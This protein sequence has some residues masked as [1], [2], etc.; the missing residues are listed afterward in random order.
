MKDIVLAFKGLAIELLRTRQHGIK[1][2]FILE[3]RE[4]FLTNFYCKEF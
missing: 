3:I 2:S 4:G 1:V